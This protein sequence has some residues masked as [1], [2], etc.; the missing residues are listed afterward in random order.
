MKR[1]TLTFLGTGASCGVPSYYCGCAACEEARVDPRAARDCS[2]LLICGLQH[3]LIDAA[4]ELRTQLIRERVSTIDQVLFT[5]EHFDH[6]GGIPQLEFFV[7]LS[8]KKPLPIYASKETLAAI[9]QQFGFM[10]EVLKPHLLEPF[11]PVRLDGILYTPL[12]AAHSKGAF[13]FLIEPQ[14]EES[15]A[16][17][18]STSPPV[19]VAYFP[20]TGPLPPQTLKRLSALDILIIDATFNGKNWMPDSHH[21]IDEAIACALAL[22]AECTYLTHLTMHYDKPIT[23]EEL[24]EKLKPY[25]GAIRV[26]YD[27]LGVPLS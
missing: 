1:P 21:T 4:P 15:P 25:Q 5:H 16:A 13:G 11:A 17:P 23:L 18:T 3:T 10:S 20:D 12:P 26:A 27:G 8:S 22:G 19:R 2:G 24:K 14:G 7:R 9:E 6:V